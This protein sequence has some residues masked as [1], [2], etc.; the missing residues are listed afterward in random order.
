LNYD[1]LVAPMIRVT[2][3]AIIDAADLAGVV[4]RCA[5]STATPRAPVWPSRKK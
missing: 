4:R 3:S 1:F 5:T 2:R